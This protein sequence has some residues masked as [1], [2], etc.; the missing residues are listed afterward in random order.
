MSALGRL[1][2][3]IAHEIN[4]PL[5]SVRSCLSLV[6]EEL[7]EGGSADVIKQDLQ[8][9]AEEVKRIVRIVRQLREFYRPAREGIEP[10]NLHSILQNVLDLVNKRLQHGNV[11]VERRWAEDLPV[12]QANPDQLKQVFLNLIINAADAMP[13]GG[14]LRISTRLDKLLKPGGDMAVPAAR[15]EFSDSGNG[16]SAEELSHLFEPFYTTKAEGTGLG[17]AV[18][19]EIIQALMGKI[20]CTS[21][22]G[23][24]TTF[25]IRLP[26]WESES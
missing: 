6:E 9:A 13:Q 4:N 17:L 8:I 1:T 3:S 26:V 23:I 19:H 14:V 2:A 12:V 11:M 20:T 24:G 16:M 10:I 7:D 25:T 22:P 5:Q 21:E 18:S 15:L